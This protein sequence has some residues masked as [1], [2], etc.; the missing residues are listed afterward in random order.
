MAVSKKNE[1]LSNEVK[2]TTTSTTV[3]TEPVELNL[4]QKVTLKN[5]A[6]W[7]VGF[8]RIESD[9]DVTIPPEG[10]ARVTRSEIIAQ[11]QNGNRLITGVDDMGSH[12]TIYIDDEATRKEIDFETDAKKQNIL[13]VE[14]VKKLF[15]YKTIK[16]FEEKL[17]ELIV[18]RAEKYAIIQIIKREKINDY[19]KV[20]IV[21]NYTG[22]SVV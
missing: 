22:F 16:T 20:R 2:D 17:K 15:E 11:A 3:E 1:A 8:R 6:G 18:T 9:G 14:S 12:A 19:E 5:I 4:D 10:S 13:T 21:E 7:T